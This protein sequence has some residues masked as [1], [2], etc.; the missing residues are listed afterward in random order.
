VAVAKKA[1]RDWTIRDQRKRWDFQSGLKQAKALMQGSSANRTRELLRLHINCHFLRLGLRCLERCLENEDS[2]THIL[3]DCEAIAYLR[4]QHMGRY[5]VEP[6]DYLDA[7]KR[8]VLRFIRSV[9]LTRINRQG[10]TINLRG[11]RTRAR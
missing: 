10:S 1:V 9:G 11:R 3:C 8:K 2:V 4:L 5:F 6:S 7:P